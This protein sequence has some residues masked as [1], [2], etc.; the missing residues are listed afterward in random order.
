MGGHYDAKTIRGDV[1][2]LYGRMPADLRRLVCKIADAPNYD[3]A[4]LELLDA[5]NIHWRADE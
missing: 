1:I 5:L 3:C 4:A 2:G